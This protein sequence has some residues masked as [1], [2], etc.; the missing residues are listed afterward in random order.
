MDGALGR[1]MSSIWSKFLK[2]RFYGILLIQGKTKLI[3]YAPIHQ[4]PN[5]IQ[6]K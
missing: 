6:S 2:Y 1:A 4:F 5:L 3:N